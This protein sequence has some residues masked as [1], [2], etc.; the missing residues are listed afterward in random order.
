MLDIQFQTHPLQLLFMC[1]IIFYNDTQNTDIVI[2][3][4]ST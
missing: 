3:K 2:C 1:T 4:I